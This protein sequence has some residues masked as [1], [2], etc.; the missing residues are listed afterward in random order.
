MY[1]I[2][3]EYQYRTEA[4]KR[5]LHEVFPWEQEGA[6]GID[7]VGYHYS[8]KLND[9]VF[10]LPKVVV[11]ENGKLFGKDE[12]DPELLLNITK[13]KEEGRISDDDYD[14]LYG[15]SVW[16]Y[17][18]IS[19]YRR[20]QDG[21]P[22]NE[23]SHIIF[24]RDIAT[25]GT[26]GQTVY[27]TMLDIMLSL[28]QFNRDNQDY[29][30]F[31]VRNIHSGYNKINWTK[32]I[33][34]SQAI[35]QGG[36]AVY[37]DAI[38]KKKQINYDEELF[39]IFFSILQHLN[40]RYG[41]PVSINFGYELLSEEEFD[42]Y[43][44]GYG[45][46]RLEQIRYKYFADKQLLLWQLCYD[47]FAMA[48]N[49][50]MSEQRDDYLVVKNFNIVFE[51]M[52]DKLLSDRS[53]K[54]IDNLN[55]KEQI[56]GKRVDH[57]YAYQ[58]LI[59]NQGDIF[60]IGDSKYYKLGN[61]PGAE[62]VYKQYTYARNV[63]QANLN[64]FNNEE[65]RYTAGKDYLVYLDKETEGYNITPNFFIRAFI[66]VKKDYNEDGLQ[67]IKSEKPNYHFPNRLF[68]R[69]TLLLQH[70][71]INFLYV[72]SVYGSDD[73]TA[74][75]AFK[76]K[77]QRLF[78]EKIITEIENEYQFFSLQLKPIEL[79][80]NDD[81]EDED[82]EV[83]DR[84]KMNRLIEQKYFHRLLGKA[85]RPFK[86]EQFLYLS[87]EKKE[88]FY[89][90]NMKLLSDLS[91]DFNIRYYK[92]GSD[93]RDT[94]N[95]FAEL[96]YAA[97]GNGNAMQ[98]EGRIFKFED[99]KD[100]VFLVGG[101]RTDKNQ[102]DWIKEHKCYN[103]RSSVNRHGYRSGE[104]DENVVSARYLVLYEIADREKRNYHVFRI[105]EW[106]RRSEQ[107][108]AKNG[109][110]S[111]NDSY[112]VYKLSDEVTFESANVNAML[113]L[114]IYKELDN[115]KNELEQSL[116]NWEDREYFGAPIFLSGQEISDFAL[117]SH[118][119]SNKA[120]VVVNIRDKD[121]SK[122][123]QGYSVALFV[124]SKTADTIKEFTTAAYLIYSNKQ[125]HKIFQIVGDS[126][127]S[128]NVPQGYLDRRYA[129]VLREEFPDKK[130][131]D[132]VEP[133]FYLNFAVAPDTSGL[134]LDQ[135]VINKVPD[136]LSGYDAH[137]IE[138]KEGGTK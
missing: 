99:F 112:I 30:T 14:F 40:Q 95:T 114:G 67:A 53:D 123:Q 16:I 117:A 38:N 83:T 78:R 5:L 75:Q 128:K 2:I 136:G 24:S 100:E 42:N 97:V 87:L 125:T 88:E 37:V 106:K 7:C 35:V 51:A 122:M 44:D 92:L 41:F 98:G 63:I 94:I 55:L 89:A 33:S 15:F 36:T 4:A 64:L 109:Y 111:P 86:E 104:I 120:L 74:Q 68:D 102:L 25:V 127:I 47:F 96:T 115:R 70:Y 46:I 13:A 65:G 27:N 105:E 79:D 118:R 134:E 130:E 62:S 113:S 138:I 10:F 9:T 29:F 72:L 19:E 81:D 3:E 116:E 6:V 71:N 61:N 52:I 57:I 110:E 76:K 107:W 8:H 23:K 80:D 39:I 31:V 59:H 26:T 50:N 11:H 85:F 20:E 60:Y 34:R 45:T 126:S 91:Q 119:Q 84:D 21:K 135:K 108:M 17:R 103:I 77:A 131:R 82:V 1:L 121:L 32:T 18:A 28:L 48:N 66:D 58:G 12:Y 90:D 49:V 93:P 101:Y 69:D 133:Q 56:D 124:A 22:D 132:K 129:E 73:E 54:R 43:L 137:V